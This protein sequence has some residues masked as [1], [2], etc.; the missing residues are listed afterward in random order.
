M[1]SVREVRRVRSKDGAGGPML[2]DTGQTNAAE[3]SLLV[4]YRRTWPPS[5]YSR[6][7]LFSFCL[8]HPI[9]VQGLVSRLEWTNSHVYVYLKVKKRSG[10]GGRMG[11]RSR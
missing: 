10:R 1:V 11:R 3:G 2:S 8:K 6:A 5:W 4:N 7:T 9:T